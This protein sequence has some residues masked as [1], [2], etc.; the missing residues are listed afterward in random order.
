M[1]SSL[2]STVL[3]RILSNGIL[4]NLNKGESVDANAYSTYEFL[5]DLKSHIFSELESTSKID[6]FRRNL[7]RGFVENLISK[8]E[9]SAPSSSTFR[10]SSS[11]NTDVKSI[12]RGILRD[13]RK[14][15]AQSTSQYSD[16]ITKYHLEDLVYKID[17]VLE[18]K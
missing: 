18:I 1:V 10:I 4:E 15:S 8:T 7:Q 12:V 5:K 9:T 11:D 16:P 13:I 6:L 14:Q 17:K 2:Q 3:S